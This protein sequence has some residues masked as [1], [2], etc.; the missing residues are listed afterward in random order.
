MYGFFITNIALFPSLFALVV[1]GFMTRIRYY[2]GRHG[3]A[4]FWFFFG[5]VSTAIMV[6]SLISP[7]I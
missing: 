7:R 1:C 5:A 6:L 2:Q 3:K 4:A